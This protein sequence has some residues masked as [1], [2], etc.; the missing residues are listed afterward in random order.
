MKYNIVKKENDIIDLSIE[1]DKEEWAN[2]MEKA[3]EQNKGKYEVQ[4]FRKGK[5]PRKAIE[6]AYGS[7]IFVDDAIDAV[8]KEHYFSIITKEKLYPVSSPSMALDK[9]DETGFKMT[10]TFQNRPSVE[11][12]AFT[13]LEIKGK[14]ASV[15]KKEV[16]EYIEN[17]AKRNARKVEVTDRAVQNGDIANINFSGS[18]DGKK[19]DGGTAENYELEIGSHSFI[20]GFEE[21]LVG[22]QIGEEKAINVTFPADYHSKDLAGKP[23]IFDVKINKIF[24]KEQP[25]IDDKWASM[26]SEFETLEDFRKDVEKNLKEQAQK[27]VDT[28]NMNKLIDEIVAKAKFNVPDCMIEDEI[29]FILNDFERRLSMQGMKLDDYL[30]YAKKTMK[31]V[32]DEQKD[33]AKANCGI[34]LVLENIIEKQDIKVEDKEID[35]KIE[36]IAKMYGLNTEDMKKN[37]GEQDLSYIKN[38][39]L[40]DKLIAFL[41]ENN[42][43]IQ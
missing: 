27:Q 28:E 5:A 15:K 30:K 17:M 38:E 39:I 42:K 11:L 4:G 41:K 34:R 7:M 3:Y 29:D 12:G 35:V 21:Q 9:F 26:V 37:I 14:K 23:S 13:G 20:E 18:V 2:A 40:M 19:F 36:E 22:M 1:L 31:E 8:Y 33:I 6:N 16:D 25:V 43:I 32:R 24:V 10:L